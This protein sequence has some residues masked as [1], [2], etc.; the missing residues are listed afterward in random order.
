[1]KLRILLRFVLAGV[2]LTSLLPLNITSQPKNRFDPD[3]AF[4]I[5]GTT[6]N[7]FSDF[8]GINLNSKRMR[9]LPA[10][11]LQ[12][13]NGRTFRYKSLTVKKDNFTF[14]TVVVG[15]VAYGFTG[16]FLKDGVF[17]S[18]ALDETTPVLEGTL[19]KYKAGKKV[20][21]ANL[22]FSYFGGT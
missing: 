17:A 16:R 9:R 6:P 21:E 15:G 5:I 2:I 14:T 13:N 20:A 1:M 10:A 22:K 7:D 18:L 4:W 3:G 12:L 19:I 11:G 8:G